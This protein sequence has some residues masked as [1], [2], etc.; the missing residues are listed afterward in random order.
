MFDGNL[1]EEEECECFRGCVRDCC[2][3]KKICCEL[4]E[5][6]ERLLCALEEIE[7]SERKCECER[8]KRQQNR[9][10]D[11]DEIRCGFINTC[12]NLNDRLNIF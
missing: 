1:F 4:R 5:E 10:C 12:R 6:K 8:H 9:R 11:F 3:R 2:C 7:E